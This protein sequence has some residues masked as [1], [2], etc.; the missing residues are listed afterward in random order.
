MITSRPN[1]EYKLFELAN[2]PEQ[3]TKDL[4]KLAKKGWRVLP[5][6]LPSTIMLNTLVLEREVLPIDEPQNGNVK[7][8]LDL[9]KY[10][11]E[12]KTRKKR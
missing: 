10:T 1:C 4:N 7:P 12:R 8:S 9:S 6:I 11:P 5:I 2:W 3:V